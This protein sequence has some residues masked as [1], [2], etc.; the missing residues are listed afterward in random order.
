[1]LSQIQGSFCNGI[2]VSQ[3]ALNLR[4]MHQVFCEPRCAQPVVRIST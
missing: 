1:M 3:V 2:G 4:R